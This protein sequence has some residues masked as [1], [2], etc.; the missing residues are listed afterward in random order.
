[1]RLRHPLA[2]NPRAVDAGV[3]LDGTRYPVDDD[4][5]IDVDEADL[6]AARRWAEGY[7]TTVSALRVDESADGAESYPTDSDSNS[8]RGVTDADET[9]TTVKADGE[10]CGR[11]RPCPYHDRD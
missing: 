3:Y 1:M 9:C 5:C 7:E 6:G 8:E 2:D 4:L 11:E 10:V